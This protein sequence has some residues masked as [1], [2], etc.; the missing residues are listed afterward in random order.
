RH[1]RFSRD[2]SSDVCSSDLLVLAGELVVG[3][4]A[5]GGRPRRR[6][7]TVLTGRS[8]GCA[9]DTQRGADHDGTDDSPFTDCHGQ[10]SPWDAGCRSQQGAPANTLRARVNTVCADSKIGNPAR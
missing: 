10:F 2:W 9:G 8:V 1:T 3:A 6:G 7:V 4:L 5:A